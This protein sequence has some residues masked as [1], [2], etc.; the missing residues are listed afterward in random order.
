MIFHSER[1]L[2]KQG[3]KGRVDLTG[4]ASNSD[5]AWQVSQSAFDADTV[6]RDAA[7]Y[8]LANGDLGVRG[9]LDEL[10]H[11]H[12]SFLPEG[13][14]RRPIRYHESFPGFAEGTDTRLTGPGLTCVR[15]EIDG[16]PADFGQAEI[17]AFQRAL[18]LQT[19]QL[20][21]TTLW[22]LA[23]G[24]EIEIRTQR[25]VP[26]GSGAVCVSRYAIRAINFSGQIEIFCP[27]AM[28]DASQPTFDAED[29]RINARAF[30]SQADSRETEHGHQW[31]FGPVAG[32]RP[33]IT[34]VQKLAG[35]SSHL[36][37]VAK[38][39]EGEAFSFDRFVALS[40]SG[41]PVS[42]GS[43][44]G[45][46]AS[47]ADAAAT[48]GF[49]ALS[50][51]MQAALAD[52]WAAS[53]VS[54]PCDPELQ[55]A[56]RFNLFHIFQSSSRSP[57]QSIAAK[58]L[59]G[60]GY[61]GHY[62]WD[63]EAFIVPVLALTAPDLARNILTYRI[64]HLDAARAH[65]R[66][67]GHA[68]GALFPWRTISGQECS[69]HYP[70][71]SAQY[72][73][74]AAI[75][76]AFE[77]YV[78]ATGDRAI[79]AEGGADLLFETARL[80]IDTGR[81]SERRGGAFVIH[82][83]TGPDEY[84]ALVDNDFYTNAMAR[85]HLLF[86]SKVARE[87]GGVGDD[88][89]MLW[90]RAAE[91]MWL[92]VDSETGVH[93]QDDGFMDKPLWP[94][95]ARGTGQGPLLVHYHPMVLFRHRLC[96]QGDVIQ[97]HANG[98][99]NASQAQILRDLAY[100]EPLTTHD[101]TLS[102]TAFAIA[103]A[104]AGTGAKSLE[105]LRETAF[106]D[107]HDLHG[108]SFHG[109]HLAAMAGSWLAIAQGWGGLSIREDAL[110]L[111]PV[112]PPGWPDYA[113]RF[114]WRGS[115]VEAKIS[116]A[117]T[118]YALK[119]GIPPDFTDHGR[120]VVFSGGFARME[121]PAFDAIIF[122]LDGVITDTAEAH[123]QAWKR[124]CDE[125]R[126]PFDRTINERLKGVERAQSLSLIAEAAGLRIEQPVFD[127]M[128]VRKNDYYRNSLAGFGPAD[129]FPGVAR[130]LAECR[131]ARLKIGLASASR[132]APDLIQR[133]GIAPCFDFVADAGAVA[134]GKPHP[135]IFLE[136][137]KAMGVAPDRCIGIEDSIAGIR[138]IRAAGMVA[139]GVGDASILSEADLVV[140]TT[141]DVRLETLFNRADRNSQSGKPKTSTKLKR[142][143]VS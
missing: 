69:A 76:F 20:N 140:G 82:G 72:H 135:D 103:A 33:I 109:C 10:P 11:C 102:A 114:R 18:D 133:L 52:F 74:N 101:S 131:N 46:E 58:G 61:E 17:R 8:A 22:R 100:Y 85:R 2:I 125:E 87:T 67:I 45:E 124:L 111:A 4:K 56:I 26:F 129:L 31:V 54:I 130:L 34:V 132:N 16:Q 12:A 78:A 62:F 68:T 47:V 94:D 77:I 98:A 79:L 51:Q 43:G 41:N 30:L 7:L 117:G 40:I 19:G 28:G 75:A 127:A 106:V 110:S 35:Q 15:V 92:P 86:A 37:A 21:R 48:A 108:N 25:L 95:T 29:P 113:F 138:A 119:D 97:A 60:E 63:T 24:R 83:V 88:E 64:D 27:V 141:G 142:E 32:D 53:D 123:F 118:C 112:C 73:V 70:T 105:Y 99:T 134:R 6:S 80:W 71:G 44:S 39:Q 120:P 65:A 66:S 139:I 84:C 38:L 91:R 115:V 5:H 42:D 137:A 89:I 23:D 81:F 50:A 14:V 116:P 126:I 59:T 36:S 13:F 143:M 93:P 1:P 104:R 122:D 107:L 121:P 9:G 128:L 96:K 49:E 90:E 55:R 57:A 136:T 3:H